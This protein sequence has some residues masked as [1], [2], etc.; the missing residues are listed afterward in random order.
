MYVCVHHHLLIYPSPLV[1]IN[2][3]SMSVSLCFRNTFSY[4]FFR[5]YISVILYDTTFNELSRSHEAVSKKHWFLPLK[6]EIAVRVTIFKNFRS[7][8]LISKNILKIIAKYI[9]IL[10]WYVLIKHIHKI[11]YIQNKNNDS[12][13]WKLYFPPH[14]LTDHL[15]CL[16]FSLWRLEM[17]ELTFP[18]LM[19]DCK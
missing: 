6:D 4:I 1:T 11:K 17:S 7:H 12:K 10:L 9:Y 5:F 8:M 15:V 13:I 19:T 14:I 3:F 16:V 2:L 18:N